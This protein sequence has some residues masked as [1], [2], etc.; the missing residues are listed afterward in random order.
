MIQWTPPVWGS[1]LFYVS[2]E[3]S[4]IGNGCA[5]PAMVPHHSGANRGNH[6]GAIT[7]H[8]R[9]HKW[10]R[11]QSRSPCAGNIR[12]RFPSP[13]GG[14]IGGRG[15]RKAVLQALWG[16][17]E[18]GSERSFRRRRKRSKRTLRRRT[19]SLVTFSRA[20]ESNPRRRRAPRRGVPPRGTRGPQISSFL[21]SLKPSPSTSWASH[22]IKK[23]LGS[24]SFTAALMAVI[25]RCLKAHIS[26]SF[27]LPV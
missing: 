11:S 4:W 19:R 26:T 9:Q 3:T 8:K 20:R 7:A 14:Y 23:A 6:T 16:E 22:T 1:P 5:P 25:S 17:E 27:S 18:Q 24:A 13:K 12:T 21:Y 2:R 10:G 15:P